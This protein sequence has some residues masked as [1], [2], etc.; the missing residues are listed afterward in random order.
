MKTLLLM[1]HAKS[2]WGNTGISDHDRPLNKRGERACRLMGSFL[3]EQNLIPDKI[4]CSTALRAKQ[5]VKGL[6]ET[7]PFA[8]DV[9]YTRDL[10]HADVDIMVEQLQPLSDHIE[11]AMLVGHNPGMDEF[12]DF[13][14]D[15]QD[16]MPTAAVAEI[17]FD[18]P[19]WHKLRANSSAKLKNLWKP[20]GIMA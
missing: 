9:D 17:E 4:I 3:H 11:V 16:H 8:N 10:Y 1:R 13:I 12:L 6:I 19:N 2:S 14:C 5:T 15:E 20:K 18:I 7:L